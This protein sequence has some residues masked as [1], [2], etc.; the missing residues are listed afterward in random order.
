MQP[1]ILLPEDR[2]EARDMAPRSFVPSR[3]TAVD[4][5]AF[6]RQLL[7]PPYRRAIARRVRIPNGVWIAL[8]VTL[9]IIAALAILHT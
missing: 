2:A 4:V 6:K 7:V 1:V 3:P 8:T 9:G 5:G